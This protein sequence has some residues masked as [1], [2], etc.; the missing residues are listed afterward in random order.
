MFSKSY[1]SYNKSRKSH[2][3]DGAHQ[4]HGGAVVDIS[5]PHLE[6]L[7]LALVVVQQVDG[8]GAPLGGRRVE[9]AILHVQVPS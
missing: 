7:R 1:L 9:V 8:E 2:A 6:L 4:L 5:F 3:R